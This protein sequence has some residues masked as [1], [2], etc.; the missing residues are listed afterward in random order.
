MMRTAIY[1]TRNNMQKIVIFG[2]GMIA[3][4]AF[5]HILRD[6]AYEVCA[7]AC[8]AN[9]LDEAGRTK[10]GSLGLPVVPFDTVQESFPPGDY[11]M[12]VAI[13][14]HDLNALRATK[15]AEAV[16]MG[17]RLVSY[18]SSRADLGEW[19]G[20]GSNCLLLDGVGLQPGSRVGDNVFVWNNSLIGHHSVVGDHCW[21]AAGSTIGGKARLGE[22]CFVGLG[23]TIGGDLDV[24]AECFVGAG[25]LVTRSA[26]ARSVFVQRDTELFRLDSRAFV[27]MTRLKTI[28]P[29]R[30]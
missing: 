14:Y 12:F 30:S 6:R 3:E 4:V 15:C 27:R 20:V 23:A 10:L 5:A 22:R 29:G 19:C 9:W 21:I 28:G 17:Y 13:G 24:A 11:A 16:R 7:F 25:A 2:L 18:V 1:R 26:A 8:D